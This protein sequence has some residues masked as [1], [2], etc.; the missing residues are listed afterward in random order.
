MEDSL[1]RTFK[2]K[3]QLDWSPLAFARARADGGDAINSLG[4]AVTFT[5]WSGNV[6]STTCLEYMRQTWPLT[7]ART[8]RFLEEL[9]QGWDNS[10]HTC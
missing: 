3:F 10:S 6:Q 7:A 8:L 9:L 4:E 1:C 5:G 2:I